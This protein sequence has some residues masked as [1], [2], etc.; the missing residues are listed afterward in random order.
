[1]R[2]ARL[3]DIACGGWGTFMKVLLVHN[4]YRYRGGE[5]RCVELQR[6]ALIDHGHQVSL[7]TR[8]SRELDGASGTR[9]ITSGLGILYSRRASRELS[10]LIRKER[11]DVA[12][13]HN[14]LP[15]ITVSAI[16]A[17]AEAAV[18]MVMTHHNYRLICP[19]GLLFTQGRLCERCPTRGNF[20]PAVMNRCVQDSSGASLAYAVALT[21][22]A[23]SYRRSVDLHL[24]PSMTV[25]RRVEARLG[26]GHRVETVPHFLADR[27][28]FPQRRRRP[29]FAYLGRLSAEKGISVLL[30]AAR[31][32]PDAD[33]EIMGEGPL[34]PA[35][36]GDASLAERVRMRGYI[37]DDSRFDLLAGARALIV[38]S[39]SMENSPYSVMEAYRAGVPVIASKIGGL[40][41]M[42]EEG[43][44]G[45]LVVPGDAVA[46]A[47]SMQLLLNDEAL[48]QDLA[49]GA[50]VRYQTRHSMAAGYRRLVDCYESVTRSREY[51]SA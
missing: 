37:S 17:L 48:A 18:P 38:P 14:L 23:S 4:H 24:C 50:R 47:S 25:R 27:D 43:K 9:R 44:S 13:L 6:Q 39:R 45:L 49:Q 12:H 35:Y 22:A 1:M 5:D 32:V 41:E 11:P 46:L 36:R 10:R 40:E 3:G 33:F 30:G 31:L 8:D 7:Y 51:A 19:N 20:V 21:F 15:L 29:Y 2:C 28:H 16:S 34:D 42:V 26:P